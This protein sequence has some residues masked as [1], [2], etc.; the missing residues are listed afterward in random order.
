[1]SCSAFTR[2]NDLLIERGIEVLT[3]PYDKV[4]IIGG[5]LR[6]STLPLSRKEN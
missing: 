3:I 4:S 5:L 2:I 1:V 6:C